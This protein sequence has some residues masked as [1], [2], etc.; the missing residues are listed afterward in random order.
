[1]SVGFAGSLVL[2]DSLSVGFAGSLVLF[3]SVSVGFA[4]FLVMSG[5]SLRSWLACS[6]LSF[7]VALVSSR[8]AD[9]CWRVCEHV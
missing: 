8:I 7:N 1:M 5:L 2:F 6:W 9:D 3:D 4:G